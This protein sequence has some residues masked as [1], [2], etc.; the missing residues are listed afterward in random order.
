M[1][2]NCRGEKA[3]VTDIHFV[4]TSLNIRN[5]NILLNETRC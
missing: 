4:Q 2:E 3:N 5:F 1:E